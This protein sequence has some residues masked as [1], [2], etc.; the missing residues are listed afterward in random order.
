[1]EMEPNSEVYSNY[2]SALVGFDKNEALKAVKN[3]N[4]C[5]FI[6]FLPL[7]LVILIISKGGD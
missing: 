2:V 1:M 6:F 7:T 5:K 3:V 4:V